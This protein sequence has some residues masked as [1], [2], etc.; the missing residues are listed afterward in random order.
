[1][2]VNYLKTAIRHFKRNK[3]YTVLNILGLSI[4]IAV[5]IIGILYV[6]N[7]L[8]YDRFHKNA[9][10]IH[11]VAVDALIGNTAIYQTYTSAPMAQAFYDFFPEIEKVN[12]IRVLRNEL[13]EFE[14][15]SIKEKEVFLVDSTFFEMFTF[16]AVKGQSEKLLYE[17]Y[18]AV[19]TESTAKRYFGNEDPIGKVIKNDTLGFRVISVVEDI[20]ENSHFHF[21]M[22]LSVTSFE[23]IYNNPGWFSNNFRTYIMLHEDVDYNDVQA[24]LPEYTNKYLYNG[25]YQDAASKGNKWELYLQPLTSIHL[26]SNIRGEFE[27]NEKKEYVYIFLAVSIFILL[28]ACIN[29]INLATAKSAGRAKEV[30]I[31]K[32]AGSRKAELIRQFLGESLLTSFISLIVALLLVEI[33]LTFLPD[34]TGV[35]LQMPYLSIPFTIPVL[36]LLGLFVGLI[37]GIYPALVISSFKPIVALKTQVIKNKG[38]AWFRN[39]L[40]VF[41]FII[42]VFLI[43]GTFI[44]YRQLDLLQN[45][46]LGFNKEQIIVVYDPHVLDNNI[47]AF[48]NDIKSLPFVKAASY[49][50][51]LPGRGLNNIGFRAD[52]QNEG[53]TLNLILTDKDFADVYE[54]GILEG[55]FF[56]DAY[57]TDTTAALINEEALKLLNYQN[58][59]NKKISNY[60]DNSFHIIGVVK[61]FHYESKHQTIQPMAILNVNG[62]WQYFGYLSISVSPGNYQNMISELNRVWDSYSTGVPFEYF[63]FDK[64]Y[65]NLYKNEMR[66]RKLFII[67]AVLSVFIACLGLLGLASYLAQQKTKEIGIRKTFGASIG[68]VSW[69]LS[70]NFTKWVLVANIIA[71]PVTWYFFDNWLDNF[72]YRCEISWL[73]FLFAFVI[74]LFIAIITVSYQTIKA[75]TANPV[76][77]LRYE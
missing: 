46:K 9:N 11:R 36:L 63:F 60:G 39:F 62:P 59:I 66:T 5:C 64:D 45:E 17:P 31:R 76:D 35:E 55:R 51:T 77:A 23:G 12:R 19:L 41:Q 58:P 57:G 53:I 3:A 10:L 16:P 1:M 38:S 14:D 54:L 7:E 43:I 25:N 61:D 33:G 30:G 72:A 40:V 50:H 4:G 6:N 15:V 47:D 69:L 8:S 32:V 2:F 48:K 24:R 56:S 73:Y 75:A 13:I 37:A 20:P 18:T 49:S 70:L 67:F 52:S 42:S 28:I 22:V 65:D 34:L 44:I 21:T 27:A 74:S 68:G 71:W 29:F 26:N